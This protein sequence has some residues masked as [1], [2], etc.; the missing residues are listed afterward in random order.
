MNDEMDSALSGSG[1]VEVI[2]VRVF[3]QPRAIVFAAFEYPDQLARWWGPKGFSSTIQAFDFRPDGVWR[4]VMHGP[5][6]MN[7]DSE[8]AFVEVL[9]PERIVFNHQGPAHPYQ[10][11][12]TFQD[13]AGKTRL[14][15]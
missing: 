9:K 8:S 15:W 4:M 7:Y 2:N 5:D 14:T 13:V 12:M 10:M 3:S 6:G 1:G 11:T